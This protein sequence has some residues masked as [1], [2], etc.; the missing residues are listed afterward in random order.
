MMTEIEMAML[1]IEDHNPDQA[2]WVIKFYAHRNHS[3]H[4]NIIDHRL[5]GEYTE[6]LK[7]VE[8]DLEQL[9]QL[10]SDCE[11]SDIAHYQ[12]MLMDFRRTWFDHVGSP[13]CEPIWIANWRAKQ[14]LAQLAKDSKN[15]TLSHQSPETELGKVQKS[16]HTATDMLQELMGMMGRG[17]TFAET[18]AKIGTAGLEL[19]AASQILAPN[20]AQR[21][22]LSRHDI[23]KPETK[24]RRNLEAS[25]EVFPPFMDGDQ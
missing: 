23:Y 9:P 18:A 25:N 22:I 7:A 4:S 6:V 13:S 2:Y 8:T 16:L 14:H 3:M 20:T 12:T 19:Q 5:R 24:R 10:V 21:D 15:A 1:N 11:G 17:A